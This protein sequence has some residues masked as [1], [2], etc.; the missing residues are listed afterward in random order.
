[1]GLKVMQFGCDPKSDSTN[2]LRDGKY[3]PTVL[4]TLKLST[5]LWRKLRR[6][7]WNIFPVP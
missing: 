3:I 5:T 4:D 2:T 6:Q 1:M 7:W